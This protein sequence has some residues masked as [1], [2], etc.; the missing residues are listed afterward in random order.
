MIY[1][2]ATKNDHYESDVHMQNH[3]DGHIECVACKFRQ[4]QSSVF[5][6]RIE[7]IAHLH[8]HRQR[9]DKVP[10]YAFNRLRQE[11]AQE[12]NDLKIKPSSPSVRELNHLR[13]R[14]VTVYETP[15]ESV[16]PA[17]APEVFQSNGMVPIPA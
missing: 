10:E 7:A 14:S 16:F 15:Q 12:G 5:F 9:G 8:E 1:C 4:G 13:K 3:E 11:M 2:I 17:A 6:K